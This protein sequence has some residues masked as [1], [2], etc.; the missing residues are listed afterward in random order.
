MREPASC[1]FV[2]DDDPSIRAAL[3]RLFQSVG[4]GC[5]TFSSAQEFLQHYSM[6]QIACLVLDVRLPGVSGLDL[7]RELTQTSMP[8]PIIFLTGYGDVPMTVRALKAGAVE[9]LT[10]PF[11]DQD[12]LDAVQQALDRGRLARQEQAEIAGLRQRCESLTPREQEV[13]ALLVRGLS[14]PEICEQLV[15]SEATAKTHVA[16]ILQKL[17]LRDRVQ[18]VIYAYESGLVAPGG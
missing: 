6:D 13:L 5:H 9:F 1:V 2:V 15:I 4:L 8:I 10:K 12:L 11:H 3:I 14:N 7:Q 18:A 16:H 17:G